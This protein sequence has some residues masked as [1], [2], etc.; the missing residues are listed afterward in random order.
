M[1]KQC[2]RCVSVLLSALMVFLSVPFVFGTDMI[3][4]EGSCG[5]A[6][7][8]TL[9]QDGTL[10]VFGAGEMTD[11]PWLEF[12]DDITSVVLAEG[13]TAVCECAFEECSALEQVEISSTVQEI[14]DS[15][16]HACRSLQQFSVAADNPAFSADSSGVL[17]DKAQT[18]LLCYPG[19]RS[20]S[21]YTLPA[22]VTSIAPRAFDASPALKTLELSAGLE[23]LGF[24]ALQGCYRLTALTV[25]DSVSSIGYGALSTCFDL[26]TLHLGSGVSEIHVSALPRTSALCCIT[27]SADNPNYSAVDGVLVNKEGTELCFYP[28]ARTDTVY[29]VPEGVTGISDAAFSENTTLKTIVLPASLTSIDTDA[30]YTCYALEEICNAS[31]TAVSAASGFLHFTP[32]EDADAQTLRALYIAL[33]QWNDRDSLLQDESFLF[34]RLSEI[35]GE[36][37]EDY[38]VC[39]ALTLL[40]EDQT[41]RTTEPSEI[42]FHAFDGSAEADYCAAHNLSLQTHDITVVVESTAATCESE[43]RTVLG[44][45]TCPLTQ[46]EITPALGHNYGNWTPL[47]DARHARICANDNAH[48]IVEAHNYNW[49]KVISAATCSAEGSVEYT[50]SICGG[51]KTV[52]TEI[53]SENHADYGTKVVNAVAAGCTTQGYTGDTVCNGCGAIITTG[54]ATNALGHSFDDWADNGDDH[55]RSC[56]RCSEEEFAAHV[57]NDGEA[58]TAATCKTAGSVKYSCTVCNA[59]KTEST[60][61]DTTNHADYGTKVVNAVAAGCTTQGYTGDTVCNGCGAIITTGETTNALGHSFDDWADNGDDHYRSCSRCSEEEFAAH[62]WNDGEVLATAT[63]KTAGSVKYTCTVCNATKTEPTEKDATNHADYGTKTINTVA[64]GCTTQGYTGDTVCNGCGAIITKGETTNAL[65]HSFDDWAGNGDNHYRSC[66]RCSEEE[67]AEHV[68]NDGEVLTTATCKTAGSV[69]YTCTVCNATKTEPTE[70]DATNHAD[71]GTK[72]VNVVAAGCTTQGYTGDTVCNGC[73]TIITKG[74]AT[75]ALGHNFD[76][77]ADNGDDHYRSCSCC[78]EEEFAA[79]VWNDGEV[80]TAATCSSTGS[81]KYICTVCNAT[82]T[83]PTEKNATNHADYGTH[84]TGTVAAGCTTQ[85]YT[86][87]TVCNGCGAIITTGETT[88]AL[89]HSFDDWADNGDD[90]YRS[91]SRCSEEEFAAHVWNDGEVITAA[92][93]KTAGSVKFT[94]T[95]CNA[96]K[97]VPTEKDAT[98]HADYGT[99]VVNAAAAGCTTQ[100]YTGDTVCNG[101]GAIITKGEATNALGHSF[102]DWADNGD[103]HYRS[104]S[105]CSEEEFAA[106]VWND[107]EV[108]TAATCSSAGS[109]KYTCTVCNASKTEPTEKDATNHADYGTKVVNAVAAGCTTQG[110]TGDTVCNGCGAIITKGEATNALGHSFGGWT[111]G[112]KAH[113][114]TCTRCSEKESAEH[115]WNDGEVL[116]AATCSSAGSVKY[117]CTVCG[118]TKTEPTE[119]NATNHADYGTKVV[120]AVTA[121]C[122]TQGYTGDTVCNGCGATITKGKVTNALG[123]SFGGWTAGEKAHVRTCTRCSEKESA[124]HIWGEPVVVS[125]PTCQTEG[126][127]RSVCTVCGAAHTETLDTVPHEDLDR[128]GTCDMCREPL[129]PAANGGCPY[130]GQSHTGLFGWLVGLLHRILYAIFGAK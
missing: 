87:D 72:V 105:R 19:G 66:S 122:T 123:H 18:A 62:V 130:C 7:E 96:T 78:S 13:V 112:E 83:E 70:K 82:K 24:N 109:V 77:W 113:V 55:Y 37:V 36:P 1:K 46:T 20:N 30:F 12:M 51:K 129:S 102:D 110:Y 89:G 38:D 121:G 118:A 2:K 56:S 74:E 33:K 75:N 8:W 115:V 41:A 57:W 119:K 126:F 101:C 16:F 42:A 93:C 22:G 59:T 65:G 39:D 14:G 104:C 40:V 48:K 50:C 44:C 111:A 31:L 91:C 15:A 116:T 61:K 97:T 9:A 54:E 32:T 95:V 114:R 92:T 125:A 60:E 94:C 23:T 108:L 76:D 52:P 5:D 6:L 98:N 69:K 34:E 64:A 81:V 27:V 4:A 3:L 11:A 86:G 28:P 71:Y 128:D 45:A 117:T 88:N 10:R 67:F 25:P 107:G 103:D 100:G 90:H 58:L 84:V 63:C 127:S 68:W 73:G 53:N 17:F 79:H 35:T 85:G 124:A 21:A 26:E 29:T 80:L 120:N 106:H 43:G 99:K 47:D 49:R